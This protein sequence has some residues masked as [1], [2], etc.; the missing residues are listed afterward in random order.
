MTNYRRAHVAG[1]TYFF[2][3][4]IA[5]RDTN[6]LVDHI[7]SLRE[8]LQYVRR[9]HPFAI[10]AMVVLP[11]H[12]HA[13][14]TLPPGDADH[15]LRWRQFKARFSR[16]VPPGEHCG[17]SRIAKGER[18]IWQRRYWEHLIRDDADLRH[19]VDYIHFN[20]VRHG[21]VTRA[22]DWPYSTLHRYVDQGL[23]AADWAAEPEAGIEVGERE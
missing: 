21:Y 4:N 16:S 2:T 22:V 19:H 23:L 8:A 20:P 9:R 13:V 10:D 14:W 18:G 17:D 5:R 3:V 11:D 1:A 15:S 6:L 7:A 12:L